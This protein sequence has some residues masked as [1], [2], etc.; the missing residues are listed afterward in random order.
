MNISIIVGGRFHA[1]NLAEQLNKNGNLS[2]II[3]SYPKFYLKNYGINQNKIESI[4]IK[5]IIQE[6]F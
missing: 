5:E 4:I 6:V 2:Q 3:T 1:F